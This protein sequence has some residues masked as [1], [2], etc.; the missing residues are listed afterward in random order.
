MTIINGK[1]YQTIFYVMAGVLRL[2]KNLHPPLVYGEFLKR[3][4]DALVIRV[5][6]GRPQVFGRL[7]IRSR[8]NSKSWV[9]M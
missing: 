2:P 3:N 7:L 9:L 1:L 4:D 6:G 8:L 5:V